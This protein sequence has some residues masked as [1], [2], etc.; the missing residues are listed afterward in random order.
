[1]QAVAHTLAGDHNRAARIVEAAM[2]NAPAGN[3]GWLLPV[4][5]ILQPGRRPDVWARALALVRRRA[6]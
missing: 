4:E 5:P 1:V 6:A 3:A 2:A